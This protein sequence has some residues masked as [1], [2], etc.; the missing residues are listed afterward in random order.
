MKQIEMT[1]DIVPEDTNDKILNM[2]IIKEVH[3]R[4]IVVSTCKNSNT[5]LKK[6][7]Q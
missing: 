1:L 5:Q 2:G 6:K 4:S 7:N 3:K